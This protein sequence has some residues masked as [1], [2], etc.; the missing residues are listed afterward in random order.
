MP[1]SETQMEARLFAVERRA[2]ALERRMDELVSEI[3]Q[4]TETTN[5]IKDDTNQML[6]L[7]KA[8]Q[9]GASV[10][11]WLATVGG[12]LIVAWAAFKGLTGH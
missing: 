1:D 4:N 2:E 5:A 3:R 12:A 7:F 10:V 8:S 9:M 11:K 6:M